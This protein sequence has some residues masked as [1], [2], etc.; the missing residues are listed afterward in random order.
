MCRMNTESTWV[1]TVDRVVACAPTVEAAVDILAA[2]V[3]GQPGQH[4]VR[5]RID[6]AGSIALLGCVTTSDAGDDW[7]EYWLGS[8]RQQLNAL[9][10]G[11]S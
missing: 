10:G 11:A 2:A 6:R 9:A 8:V 4:C 5:W 7:Y 1:V 3:R